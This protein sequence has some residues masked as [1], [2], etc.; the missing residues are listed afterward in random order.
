MGACEPEP[1][2]PNKSALPYGLAEQRADSDATATRD[3]AQIH[4]NTCANKAAPMTQETQQTAGW[5]LLYTKPRQEEV[6][7]TH[8]QNQHYHAYLPRLLGE[9][10]RRGRKC[11]QSMP[12]FPRYLFIQ[13]QVGLEGP[14]WAPIRS[15]RGVSHFVRFGQKPVQVDHRLIEALRQAE[16]GQGQSP[17]PL[18]EPGERLRITQGPYTGLTAIFRMED[19]ESRASVLI[20]LL[21]KPVPLSLPFDTL[22]R[23]AA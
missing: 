10:L 9:T 16:A 12:L 3:G 6:A 4:A 11:V 5:F 19:G 14:S 22:S 7:L 20:E 23:D 15:T 1:A 2:N 17:A 21:K 13:L 18:F 8:L